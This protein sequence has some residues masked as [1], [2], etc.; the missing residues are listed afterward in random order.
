MGECA[1]GASDAGV[2]NSYE[3]GSLLS[4]YCRKVGIVASEDTRLQLRQRLKAMLR[5]VGPG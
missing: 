2:P 3:L 5:N 4:W 1:A